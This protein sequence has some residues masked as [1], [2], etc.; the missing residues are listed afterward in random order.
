MGDLALVQTVDCIQH[1]LRSS[2]VLGRIGGEEFV[3]LLPETGPLHAA[4]VAERLRQAISNLRI[5]ATTGVA[6]V[7]STES[8]PIQLTISVGVTQLLAQDS[9]IDQTLSR[10]DQ[11]LYRAKRS[12]RNRV[13]INDTNPSLKIPPLWPQDPTLS[14]L[15]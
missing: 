14:L 4:Q 1:E 5:V 13:E 9:S 7:N 8:K 15:F 3:M 6:D 10:A 2:D 11:A 12:G